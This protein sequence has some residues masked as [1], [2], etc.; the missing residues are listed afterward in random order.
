MECVIIGGGAAGLQAALHCRRCW[1]EKSV[2]LI[3]AEGDVGYCNPLL[4]QF[5][6]GQVEEEKLF[7]WQPAEDPLLQIRKGIKIQSLVRPTQSLNLDNQEKIRYERLILAPGGQPILPLLRREDLPEGIFPVRTLTTAR[8][9][10]DW[11]L[12]H[13]EIVVLG[14]GLVGVKTAAYLQLAGFAVSLVEKEDHLLPQA[15]TKP[16]ARLVERHLQRLGIRLFLGCLLEDIREEKGILKSAKVSGQWI[17]G[18]TLLIAVGSTPN[19][20]FLK[21]SGLLQD[22]ELL[23]SPTLQTADANIFAAGDAVT[24]STS[25]GEKHKLWT[26]PQAVTQGKLAAENLFRSVPLPLNVLTRPNSMNLQGLSIVILGA[27][28]PDTAIISHD[29]TAEGIYRELFIRG[30]KIVGGALV[31]DISG[32]GLLHF[33]MINGSEVDGDVARFLKPQSRVFYQLLPSSKRQR[34]RARILF[35]K[36]MLS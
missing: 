21:N 8:K 12:K 33:L 32:A 1:P 13:K 10:R 4:P 11:L 17:P 36:E 3:E 28:T 29:R 35:P 27:P 18:E 20:N 23:V 9:I 31:G 34:R 22:G 26:W 15:L 5:M 7:F 25:G 24:I 6:A 14:G 2:L 16:S 19:I 30:R